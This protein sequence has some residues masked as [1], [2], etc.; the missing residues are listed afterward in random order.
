[1]AS[2]AMA[3]VG[4]IENEVNAQLGIANSIFFFLIQSKTISTKSGFYEEKKK[5]IS[6]SQSFLFV[7]RVEL[8]T[9]GI[10][11]CSLILRR[12]I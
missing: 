7:S 6:K 2:A 3:S 4:T 11:L 9:Q 1:M 10:K 5:R 12:I 8:G